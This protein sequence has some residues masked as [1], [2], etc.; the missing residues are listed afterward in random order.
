MSIA[1]ATSIET[2]PDSVEGLFF[3]YFERQFADDFERDYVNGIRPIL[4]PSSAAYEKL[5]VAV[6]A[7]ILKKSESEIVDAIGKLG[8]LQHAVRINDQLFFQLC[9]KSM[10]DW[11]NR[12]GNRYK[13]SCN[14][15]KKKLESYCIRKVDEFDADQLAFSP[16]DRYPLLY[17]ISHLYENKN[18]KDLWRLLGP[19]NILARKQTAYFGELRS[20]FSDCS[21]GLKFYSQLYAETS[22]DNVIPRWA[23]MFLDKI[24]FGQEMLNSVRVA[25]TTNNLSA[26]LNALSPLD[27]EKFFYSC[28][29]L[30]GKAHKFNW[31]YDTIINSVLT[32]CKTKLDIP[33]DDMISPLPGGWDIACMNYLALG[34]LKDA[35]REG[36]TEEQLDKLLS[37]LNDKER[38]KCRSDEKTTTQGIIKEYLKPREVIL[39]RWLDFYVKRIAEKSLEQLEMSASGGGGYAGLWTVNIADVAIYYL[40]RN[41]IPEALQKLEDARRIG[42]PPELIDD[43]DWG[44]IAASRLILL[45]EIAGKHDEAMNLL[46]RWYP[47]LLNSYPHLLTC[48]YFLLGEESAGDE[49]FVNAI[50]LENKDWFMQIRK[51]IDIDINHKFDHY[52]NSEFDPVC[53][54]LENLGIDEDV[55]VLKP[56]FPSARLCRPLN[57]LVDIL[58]KYKDRPD[59]PVCKNLQQFCPELFPL[60]SK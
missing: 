35:M 49:S 11:L 52:S 12:E 25:F 53:N 42:I 51:C 29:F 47:Q 16:L 4:E 48:L 9:H 39:K 38:E 27:D 23:R 7:D 20:V 10:W 18:E 13:I 15:G 36:L 2:L 26:A 32:R 33:C 50:C 5:S 34:P 37:V 40:S 24:R 58:K 22:N 56:L 14:D 6:L 60:E 8:T 57:F 3:Q 28:C 54:L 30:L 59:H 43:P 17:V 45:Y 31:D 19:G 55:A 21:K 44:N 41:L 46:T 1:L